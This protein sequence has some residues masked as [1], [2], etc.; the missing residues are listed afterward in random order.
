NDDRALAGMRIFAAAG[1]RIA[2][3][4]NQPPRRKGLPIAEAQALI[5]DAAG[6]AV[7]WYVCKH[8]NGDGCD[9]RKPLPGLLLRAVRAI[10]EPGVVAWMIGDKWSDMLAGQRAGVHTCLVG[11]FGYRQDGRTPMEPTEPPE[12]YCK[13]LLVA[14][15]LLTGVY[16]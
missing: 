6:G 2:V 9:C 1:W 11:H 15:E 16:A 10:A 5:D 4:T 3:V 14:A 12:V 7:P 8:D 13:D